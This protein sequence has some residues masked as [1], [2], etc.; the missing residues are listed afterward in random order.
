METKP[1]HYDGSVQNSESLESE[2]NNE[3]FEL[4]DEIRKNIS[5]NPY[6]NN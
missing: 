4:T 5:G 6:M 1:L 3:T 2:A